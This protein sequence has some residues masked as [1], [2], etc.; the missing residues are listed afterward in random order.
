M[1]PRNKSIRTLERCKCDPAFI[2]FLLYGLGYYLEIGL[3]RM[4]KESIII[5]FTMI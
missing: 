3:K 4:R 5:S 2:S 1:K